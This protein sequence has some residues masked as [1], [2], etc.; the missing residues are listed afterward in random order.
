[1]NLDIINNVIIDF[2]LFYYEMKIISKSNNAIF[3]SQTQAL[4][5]DLAL[6][7]VF[8]KR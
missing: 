2:C 6:S 1:M 7:I 8:H 4:F 3:I 5:E